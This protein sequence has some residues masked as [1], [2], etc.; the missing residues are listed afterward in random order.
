MKALRVVGW[1]GGAALIAWEAVE[2]YM[3]IFY[4]WLG[5]YGLQPNLVIVCALLLLWVAAAV[6]FRAF[7]WAAALL[8]VT[9][10]VPYL[11]AIP[12]LAPGVSTLIDSWQWVLPGLVVL[13]VLGSQGGRA[14]R[15]PGALLAI[16]GSLLAVAARIL[17]TD[18]FY[19]VDCWRLC[20]HS[21]LVLLHSPEAAR[22][23]QVIAVGLIIAGLVEVTRRDWS[24][25]RLDRCAEVA[26]AACVTGLLIIAFT[27]VPPRSSWSRIALA[28]VELGVAAIAASLLL[29]EARER[30]LRRRLTETA[31]ELAAAP[32]P[33]TLA[34][35]LATRLGDDHLGLAFCGDN[36]AQFLDPDG[37]PCPD[38]RITAPDLCT[39]VARGGELLGILVHSRPTD[40][41]RVDR[42][43]GPATR[44][45]LENERLRASAMAELRE[46]EASRQRILER[47]A[48]ERR[49]LERNLHDGAQQR[50]VSLVLLLRMLSARVPAASRPRVD[51]VAAQASALLEELRRIARG[52]HPAVVADA[53]LPAALADLAA[54]SSTVPVTVRG[55]AAAGLSPV[56]QTTAFEL[57]SAALAHAVA[58]SARSFDVCSEP[59]GSTL[60]VH[61]DHDA[62]GESP[63]YAL[64][65]FVP[66]V[67]ALSGQLR[68][69][70]HPGSWRIRLELPCVS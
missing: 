4:T 70:G 62:P 7:R 37:R 47:A 61:V 33:G 49:T 17:M 14:S 56:A 12:T 65:A 41:G 32:Q 38:P 44:L 40:P 3:V 1:C 68:F 69:D 13:A 43:L 18:P 52:I 21:T 23:L 16:A 35:A 34:S 36:P 9:W 63:A 15:R 26:A 19:D 30:D 5:D 53:G 8:A 29:R 20:S 28:T 45:S 25:T 58:G 24:R 6:Q 60:V 48:A 11:T 10:P 31:V 64:G 67:E 55:Q 2:L 22:Q 59:H 46:L 66:F 54:S 57:V 27:Q 42:A 51:I 50:V 39:E